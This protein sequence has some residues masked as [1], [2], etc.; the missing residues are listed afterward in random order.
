MS[1]R[2]NNNETDNVVTRFVRHAGFTRPTPLQSTVVPLALQGRDLLV[3]AEHGDGKTGAMIIPLLTQLKDRHEPT[4]KALILTG[5]Q[6]KITSIVHQFKRFAPRSGRRPSIT[7]VGHEDNVRKE[8]RTLKKQTDILVGTPDR[9]IDH[10]RRNN[11]ELSNVEFA[12]LDVPDNVDE[13]GFDKD[14]HFV[15]SKMR[16]RQQTVAFLK[17]AHASPTIESILRRPQ[18]VYREHWEKDINQGSS[19]EEKQMNDTERI[20]NAMTALVKRV[21]EGESPE[22]LNHY[23]KLFRK[24]I[25]FHLRSYVSALFIQEYLGGNEKI[26]LKKKP[27]KKSKPAAR[28]EE[29]ARADDN[30]DG[31]R[32]LFVSIGKNRKVYP[33]DLIKLF[34]ESGNLDQASIGSIKILDSYSFVD[35]PVD[36]AE[37]AIEALNGTDF[38][39]RTITVNNAR[40]K[41]R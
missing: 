30:P 18:A 26:L 12:M 21:K 7:A 6:K 22:I 39:G 34:T 9:V 11:V 28:N 15:Y 31:T 8:L 13:R 5:S 14:V 19:N 36:S 16:G 3:E 23:R 40:K 37:K 2:T 29:F 1:S 25:P 35:V 32:T 41:K 10:I 38:R 4:I 24:H 33:K 17:D 20:K 27:S